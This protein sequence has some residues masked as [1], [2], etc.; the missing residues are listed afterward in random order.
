MLGPVS[1][2]A[3]RRQPSTAQRWFSA[4]SSRKQ[5]DLSSTAEA[6]VREDVESRPESQTDGRGPREDPSYE[7]WLATTGRQYKRTD[8]RNWLGGSVVRTCAH[9]YISGD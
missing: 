7:E 3:Y 5:V 6:A 4:S 9:V 2:V 1:R 8:I